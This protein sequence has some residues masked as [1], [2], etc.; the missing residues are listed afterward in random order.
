MTAFEYF[1]P[2][3]LEA[4]H[5]LRAE[6]PGARWVA[7]GTDVMVQLRS[8]RPWPSA[9]ISLR[10]V[11]ELSGIEVGPE[12]TR[13]GALV[14]IADL[15]GHRELA[16]RLPAL[17][18]AA[19]RLG[20][21]QVRNAATIGGNLANCSPCADTPPPLLVLEATARL[22]GP[23]GSVR[24]VPVEALFRG[25]GQTCLAASEILAG[26][27]VP[28]PAGGT[29]MC[30]LRKG[31]VAMDLALA[32][33]AVL[34]VMEGERC[35]KARVA[36]GAVASTPLRLRAVEAVLEGQVITD[37]RLAEARALTSEEV[38]PIDDQRASGEYR[39]ALVGALVERA[40]R[41]ATSPTRRG[42]A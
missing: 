2:T 42:G 3:S 35:V 32:S 20:S 22:V 8:G 30:Y 29:G 23:D 31:R 19:R 7:G 39:R 33:A 21:P 13:I 36:V 37:A 11:P 1:K 16:A 15:I 5:Q 18:Q 25:P 6:H 27:R 40:A 26:L 41:A 17:V 10:H 38:T 28:H 14:P 9:L 4:A 24:E 34:L 12:Q